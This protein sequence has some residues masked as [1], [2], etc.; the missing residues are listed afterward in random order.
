MEKVR[1][2]ITGR[3]AATSSSRRILRVGIH[4]LAV[5]LVHHDRAPLGQGVEEAVPLVLLGEGSGR[6]VRIADDHEASVDPGG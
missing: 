4:V 3:P 1:R 2:R 6:V 5:R